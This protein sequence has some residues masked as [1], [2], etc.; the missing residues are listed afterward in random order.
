MLLWVALFFIVVGI[1]MFIHK[2]VYKS[3]MQKALGR[4]VEDRELTSLSAWM[5][6]DKK[7]NP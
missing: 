1:F 2:I 4:E 6:Q 3:R 7:P 5:N